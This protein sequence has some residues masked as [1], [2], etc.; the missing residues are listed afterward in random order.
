MTKE[1][2]NL[3]LNDDVLT[4]SSEKKV[5]NEEKKDNY[6]RREF[7]FQSFKRSFSLPETVDSANI[8]AKY[9]NGILTIDLPK[10]EEAKPQPARTIEIG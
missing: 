7:S 10:K 2:F 9:E 8:H 3:E 1:D 5:E 6:T 4:I